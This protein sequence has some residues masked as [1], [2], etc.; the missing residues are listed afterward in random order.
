MKYYILIFLFFTDIFCCCAQD[1]AVHLSPKMFDQIQGIPISPL[2]G[3]L[4][5]AGHDS[6]WASPEIN[7]TSWKKMKPEQVSKNMADKNGRIE[8]WF[9]IKLWIDSSFADMPLY[10]GMFEWSAMDIYV[11]GS[12]FESYGNT[13]INGKAFTN[14]EQIFRNHLSL[15]HLVTG[16]E[17]VVAYHFVNYIPRFPLNLLESELDTY[18]LH[19]FLT[20]PKFVE[21]G[22][23]GFEK[24]V[25]YQTVQITVCFILALLFWLLA[26]QNPRE[27]NLRLIALCTTI[28][29]IATLLFYIAY[30]RKFSLGGFITISSLM[31]LFGAL[32][33]M[34]ILVILAKIFTNKI[35]RKLLVFLSAISVAT[36][37][38]FAKT[39]TM[40]FLIISVLNIAT[41]LY[42]IISSWKSL[43]GAQWAIVTGVIVTFLWIV[44]FAIIRS[45]EV[46]NPFMAISYRDITLLGIFLSF[47]LSLLV[48]VSIRFREIIREV[49]ENAQRVMQISE[50]KRQQ[51]LNQQKTLEQ[52]VKRQTADLT[53]TLQN[54]KSTQSQLIQSEKMASLGELT[55]GIAHEIQNPL[56]FVNNFSEINTELIDEA[57][58]EIDKGNVDEVKIILNDIKENE[59]KINHHGKRDDAIVKGMLEHSRQTKGVK[60][61]TDINMLADEYLQLSYHGLRAKDKDFNAIMKTD[62]DNSIGKI[63][64]IPQDIGRVLL[65]LFNN[66]FYAVNEKKNA[67]LHSSGQASSAG[68]PYEPTVIVSTKTVKPPSGGLGVLLTVSDNGNGIPQ[69]IID[70]IFQP[71][72]TTKPT[73]EGTGLGLSLSYDII[74]A[75]GGEIKV[76]TKE[77]EGTEFIIQL[78]GT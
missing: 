54:L 61:P 34:P 13:G 77:G 64:I 67:S 52:E 9:R 8:G 27:A 31:S 59:Q 63:N 23:A 35:P 29:G 68:R 72:F 32:M 10:H 71:F 37:Y 6:T 17:H 18:P 66:A 41:A 15:I 43:K 1:S 42:Y 44:V 36:F 30:H 78:P 51:A 38:S 60:Q 19:I 7:T 53:D 49:R 65:N 24:S 3:W 45:L 11:D 62:F 16:K 25:I 21:L 73:G 26:F 39:N 33:F 46:Q 55:A 47:P 4:F 22:N 5:H 28:F 58:Q 20:G 40:L 74:K 76:E 75:H 50:E 69:N 70:K 12:L 56:N 48:Y 14:P 2:D 57:G